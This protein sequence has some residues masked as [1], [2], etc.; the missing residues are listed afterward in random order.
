MIRKIVLENFMSHTR[1]VIEPAD[2]LTVLAGPNNCGKSAVV[3]ALQALCFNDGQKSFVRHGEKEARVAVETDEGHKVEWIRKGDVVRY[4]V[5]G[6]EVDRLRGRVPDDLDELLRLPKV[7]DDK[8]EEFDIHFAEQKR[9]I[10]LL[11]AS[12]SK[13]ATFFASSSD[14]GLLIQMQQRHKEKV[15]D[16]RR[17][18]ADLARRVEDGRSRLERYRKLPELEALVSGLES[19]YEQIGRRMQASADLYNKAVAIENAVRRASVENER[20]QALSKLESPPSQKDIASLAKT[21]N[22]LTRL[23]RDAAHAEKTVDCLGTLKSIPKVPDSVPLSKLVEFIRGFGVGI[24]AKGR[25]VD[26]LKPLGPPPSLISEVDLRRTVQQQRVAE[27]TTRKAADDYKK[28]LAEMEAADRAI[29]DHVRKHPT[30]PTCGGK[31]QIE[32]LLAGGHVHA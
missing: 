19:K 14:A 3:V 22:A 10:F 4:R 12:G 23:A 30:C 2:G 27:K 28:A 9:P 5:N 26:V 8:G 16:A 20:A 31:L 18:E 32:Q 21:V 1:T 7:V 17:D 6:R 24:A 15:R 11:D 25:E 13:A 29:R